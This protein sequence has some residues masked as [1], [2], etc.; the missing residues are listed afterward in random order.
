M[1]LTQPRWP[2]M[3]CQVTKTFLV[4]TWDVASPPSPDLTQLKRSSR[5]ICSYSKEFPGRMPLRFGHDRRS[6][7]E[8]G[9]S[10]AA[11]FQEQLQRTDCCVRILSTKTGWEKKAL[12]KLVMYQSGGLSV[13]SFCSTTDLCNCGCSAAGLLSKTAIRRQ[14]I[15]ISM[16][17][18][19]LIQ[20]YLYWLTEQDYLA[21][22]GGKARAKEWIP[23]S[24]GF[25]CTF[26]SAVRA[27]P[28]G[29]KT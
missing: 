22:D 20:Y 5:I 26:V 23:D 28:V 7:Q 27:T 25:L 21:C 1:D 15:D 9:I 17:P 4:I 2:L 18:E 8:V 16:N 19:K 6:P 29:L 3:T 11:S 24:L 12:K 10:G 14:K 13:S